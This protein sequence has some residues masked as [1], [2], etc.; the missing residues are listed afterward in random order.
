MIDLVRLGVGFYL[1]FAGF[2]GVNDYDLLRWIVFIAVLFLM[3]ILWNRE[4]VNNGIKTFYF[5]FFVIIIVL[6]NP[7]LPIYLYDRSTWA[8]IDMFT[9]ILLIIKPIVINSMMDKDSVEYE[10]HFGKRND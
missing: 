2:I 7:I 5:L 3:Y 1:L 9:G 4:K 8:L 10:D 6:F